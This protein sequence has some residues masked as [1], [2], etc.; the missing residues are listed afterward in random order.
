MK[1]L[2]LHFMN[3]FVDAVGENEPVCLKLAQKYKTGG[4]E[5]KL[6]TR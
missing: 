3:S 2:G 5:E 1:P 6:E 4:R